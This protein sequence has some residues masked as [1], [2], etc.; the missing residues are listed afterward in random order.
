MFWTGGAWH[1]LR[2]SLIILFLFCLFFVAGCKVGITLYDATGDDAGS[3][4]TGGSSE[5]NA[6]DV[7][8]SSDDEAAAEEDDDAE[9][10]DAAEDEEDGEGEEEDVIP[11]VDD[12]SLEFYLPFEG[13]EGDTITELSINERE[14]TSHNLTVSDTAVYGK[15]GEFNGID[16]YIDFGTAPIG[17]EYEFTLMAWMYPL[18]LDGQIAIMSK[19]THMHG[20]VEETDTIQFGPNGDAFLVQFSSA[21]GDFWDPSLGTLYTDEWQQVTATYSGTD[22]DGTMKFYIDGELITTAETAGGV[23]YENSNTNLLISASYQNDYGEEFLSMFFDG[24]IDEI[25]IFSRALEGDEVTDYITC[26]EE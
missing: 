17:L 21:N 6:D 20:A 3:E 9:E 8:D 23:M 22:E 10:D 12:D 4:E 26:I 5:N 13:I 11:C 2:N 24:Y 1:P 25:M 18:S 14:G 16:T 19:F 7:N 15:S